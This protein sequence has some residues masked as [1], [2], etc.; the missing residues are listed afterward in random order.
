MTIRLFSTATFAALLGLSLATGAAQAQTSMD[1]M[2]Q[3][4]AMKTDTMSKD[5]MKT[6]GMKMS[7]RKADCMHKAGM[8][9]NSMK[10]SNMM[11]S[12]E[13]MK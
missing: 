8:E 6:D 2:K 3:P 9:K 7:G 13:A 1:S 4:D 10:K 12:C 11:K 5:S